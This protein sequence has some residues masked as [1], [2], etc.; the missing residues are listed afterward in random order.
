VKSDAATNTENRIANLFIFLLLFVEAS[1]VRLPPPIHAPTPEK[2]GQ[3]QRFFLPGLIDDRN[4]E[5][6]C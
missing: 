2:R 4:Q 3:T 1:L 5:P 6:S